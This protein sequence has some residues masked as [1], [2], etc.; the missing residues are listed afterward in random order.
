M[1][2]VPRI[3]VQDARGKVQSGQAVLVCGY[4]EPEK[5]QALRLEGAI[6]IQEYRSRRSGL[7][8]GKELIFYCA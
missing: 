1:A 5:F 6:S 7:P 4:E 8:K 2:S 3:S